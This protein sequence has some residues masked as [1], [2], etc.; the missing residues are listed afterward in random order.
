MYRDQRG[1][2]LISELLALSIVGATLL[3]LL[4]GL[5]VSSRGAMLVERRVSAE[6]HAR[7]Q[8]E[9]IKTAPY[10][11]NP[12]AVPYPM[13][14]TTNA[15]TVAVTVEGWN[16]AVETFEPLPLAE[17]SGLQRVIVA[18]YA[19]MDPAGPVFSLEDYKG[20]RP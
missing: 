16:P 7:R 20:D 10:Q 19:G 12:T 3:I 8:I 15:Y 2:S 1:A 13:I 17:D 18:I 6:N 9:A 5:S 14:E 11:A 4:N